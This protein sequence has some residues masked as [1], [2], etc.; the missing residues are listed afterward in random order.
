[1]GNSSFIDKCPYCTNCLNK[2]FNKKK[3]LLHSK[4][5]KTSNIVFLLSNKFFNESM[6]KVLYDLYKEITSRD[7]LDEVYITFAVKCPYCTNYNIQEDA[8]KHCY[9]VLNYELSNIKY[10]HLF[11]FGAAWQ[12]V[13]STKPKNGI[14]KFPNAKVYVMDSIGTYYKDKAR[15]YKLKN[16]LNTYL[17]YAY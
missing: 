10:S 4:G 8:I 16:N 12:S 2:M 13:F 3:I 5:N 6:E 7:V 11:V 15:Y 14:Y 17:N 1:M 9:N